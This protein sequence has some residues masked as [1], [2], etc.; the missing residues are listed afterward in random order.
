MEVIC[1]QEE[2]F[3]ELLEKVYERLKARDKPKQ[4]KWISGEEAM[5]KLR[6]TSK[7]TLQKMRDEGK[8]RFAQPTKKLI[9]YDSDSINEYLEDNSY[10]TF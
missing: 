2:A 5:A 9:L 8:I 6:I 10:E 4:E 3:Y 7:T 1:L